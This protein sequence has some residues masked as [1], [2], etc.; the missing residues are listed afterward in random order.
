M[1]A[2]RCGEL[3]TEAVKGAPWRRRTVEHARD[4]PGKMV[5]IDNA[6]PMRSETPYRLEELGR[7]CRGLKDV[8]G[9]RIPK[10]ETPFLRVTYD[11][12]T[13]E[14]LQDAELNLVRT[15][16]IELVKT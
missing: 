14:A 1:C 3:L 2:V 13:A 11:R 8:I 15:R 4:S 9:G 16:S 12:R 7:H 6:V 5:A 10:P